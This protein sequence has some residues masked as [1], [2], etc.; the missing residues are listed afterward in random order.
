MICTLPG[1]KAAQPPGS[2][3]LL[4]DVARTV[5]FPPAVHLP[6]SSEPPIP[7]R[8]VPGPESATYFM[9]TWLELQALNQYRELL[10]KN[11]P[12]LIDERG[13]LSWSEPRDDDPGNLRI[14]LMQGPIDDMV[15]QAFRRSFVICLWATFESCIVTIADE[16]AKR[17][18]LTN[19]KLRGEREFLRTAKRYFRDNLGLTLL[20]SD[21]RSN[22]IHRLDRLRKCLVHG[23]GTKGAV[24]PG[25]WERIEKDAKATEGLDTSGNYIRIDEHY[26]ATAFDD[27]FHVSVSLIEAARERIDRP[28][29][30]P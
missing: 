23:Y 27:V 11:L 6:S 14:W 17:A 25:N 29:P 30:S 19:P 5:T 15:I 2:K 13:D 20:P 22:S 8:F 9:V 3:R 26:L 12:R 4:V 10:E 7:V 16:L 24:K 21:R 28:P 1:G 18:G